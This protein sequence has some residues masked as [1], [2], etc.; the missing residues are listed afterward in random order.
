MYIL[1]VSCFYHDSAVA[2]LKDGQLV[3]AAMEER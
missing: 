2:L 3:A 1:G